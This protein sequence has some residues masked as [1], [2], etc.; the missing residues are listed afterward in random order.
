MFIDKLK[1]LIT[2]GICVTLLGVSTIYADAAAM[3][4]PVAVTADFWTFKFTPSWYATTNTKD[5]FDLNLRANQGPHAVWIGHYQRDSEFEQTRIGYEYT[6]QLGFVQLVPS[7]QL[8]TH[9]FAGGSINAQVGDGLF[10][11][12]GYGYTNA[13]DYYN[14]NF[15]PNDA[16]T[17]GFGTTLLPKSTLS[18]FSIRDNRLN[19]EQMVVH[20]VWRMLPDDHQRWT[21]DVSSK[22]GRA[23]PHDES[24]SGNAVTVT[25]DNRDIFFRL[26]KDW[27]VNFSTEDQTRFTAGLRF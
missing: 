7:L 3:A 25:Y 23:T 16:V 22:H 10:A 14:L 27:K 20:A 9:D 5:A 21:L 12:L 8:A 11:L 17:Y 26:A 6:A 13:Q 19:T 24:I 18:L 2:A 4:E 15:D 1:N